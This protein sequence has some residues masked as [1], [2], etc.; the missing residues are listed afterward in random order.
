MEKRRLRL[1]KWNSGL[2]DREKVVRD[3]GV[4]GL[5]FTRPL[6]MLCANMYTMKGSNKISKI[7]KKWQVTLPVVVRDAL[8]IKPA[9]MVTFYITADETVKVEKVPTLGEVMGSVMSKK[10]FDVDKMTEAAKEYV[11]DN[12]KKKWKLS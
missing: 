9:D 10:P 1:P 11:V 2:Y 8:R 4:N 3:R 12:Y 7:T 5:S 6:G